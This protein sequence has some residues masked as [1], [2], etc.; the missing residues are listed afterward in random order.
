EVIFS[1]ADNGRGIAT[2]DNEKVFQVFRRARNSQDVRGTG[3]G[4]AF[5]QAT[6]RRLGGNIW[7]KSTL[8]EG[9][10]FFIQLPKKIAL[11]G[12]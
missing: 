10:V 7:F 6:V 1:I 9:T 3:M 5:V 11:K 12:V 8:N 4:M 2:D